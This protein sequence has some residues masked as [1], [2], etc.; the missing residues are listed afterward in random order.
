MEK[1]LRL[2]K[3]SLADRR[4]DVHQP[5]SR[6]AVFP[7]DLLEAP[8]L[9]DQIGA[10][11]VHGIDHQVSEALLQPVRSGVIAQPVEIDNTECLNGGWAR[12]CRE[13]SR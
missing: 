2:G 11:C 1:K 10:D 4:I 7:E 6:Q 5:A 12:G 13:S 3:L 9:D 8:A